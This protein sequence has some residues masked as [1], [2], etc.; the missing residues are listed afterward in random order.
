MKLSENIRS[1]SYLKT[2]TAEIIRDVNVNRNTLIVTQNGEA[3]VD[4]IGQEL[5]EAKVRVE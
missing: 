3:K 1:V 4:R 5:V 2:H